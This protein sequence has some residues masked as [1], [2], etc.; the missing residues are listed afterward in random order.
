MTTTTAPNG[1][2][3][4]C[5]WNLHV[6]CRIVWVGVWKR[7]FTFLH[8][9]AQII[10][11]LA[12][13]LNAGRRRLI[14]MDLHFTM[15]TWCRLLWLSQKF[16]NIKRVFFELI[17]WRIALH[18]SDLQWNLMISR[19]TVNELLWR[20][21]MLLHFFPSCLA[22]EWTGLLLH[23]SHNIIESIPLIVLISRHSCCRWPF[24]N[25]PKAGVVFSKKKQ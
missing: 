22:V 13:Q 18:W 8:I 15:K 23:Y 1:D 7:V 4:K 19:L 20:P 21:I 14:G 17:N 6:K 25:V 16:M 12:P 11:H 3:D 24:A 9:L 5:N 10:Q 2:D